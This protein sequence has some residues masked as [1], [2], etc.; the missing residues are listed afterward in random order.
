MF[1]GTILTLT[2][3]AATSGWISGNE[4]LMAVIPGLDPMMVN[5]A[6]C[7]F[8]AGIAL[9]TSAMTEGRARLYVVRPLA[10]ALIICGAL[11]LAEYFLHKD[12]GINDLIIKDTFNRTSFFGGHMTLSAALN[13]FLSGTALLFIHSPR[14]ILFRI[15]QTTGLLTGLISGIILV[16]YLYNIGQGFRIGPFSTMTLTSAALFFVLAVGIFG[17]YPDRGLFSVLYG[18]GNGTRIARFFLA[19]SVG[20]PV[21]VGF[22]V[23]AGENAGLFITASGSAIASIIDVIVPVIL[24]ILSGMWLNRS[25]QLVK[26]SHHALLKSEEHYRGLFDHMVEGCANH[27]MLFRDGVP[28]DYI[29]LD[30]NEAFKNMTGLTNVIGKRASEVVHNI[31]QDN[32]DI[33]ERYREVAGSARPSRFE[34]F[35]PALK[36]W[37]SIYFYCLQNDE[38]VTVIDNI[39]KRKEA[40][41]VIRLNEEKLRTLFEVLPVGVSFHDADSRIVEMNNALVKILSASEEA[42]LDGSHRVRTFLDNS[43]MPVSPDEWPVITAIREKMS[44]SDKEIGIRLE[45][46]ETRWVN[47]N[48]APVSI[49]NLGAVVVISDITRQKQGEMDL[50]ASQRDLRVTLTRLTE[51]EEDIRRKAAIELHDQVGQNLTALVI[52]MN[53]LKTQLI[54]GANPKLMKFLDDSILLLEDTIARTRDIMTE[55]RPAVLEDYG[56]YAAIQWYATQFSGRTGLTVMVKGH[57]LS[58]P[59]PS[60]VEYA[61]FRIVQEAFTNIAKHAHARK[62]CI[63]LVE[64]ENGVI[65]EIKDDG[66]GF[67]TGLL[68]H[69]EKPT[70]GMIVM[71]ERSKAAGGIFNITSLPGHG[72]TIT[73]KITS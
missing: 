48:A 49:A 12:I 11:T 51:M 31:Q 17:C 22:L 66:V 39:T 64:S 14:K 18:G 60:R 6:A 15:A 16:G 32:T 25:E 52:N 62:A 13:F 5:T 29:Y 73:F 54:S 2:G 24:I 71:K 57:D 41:E 55:L 33:F 47:V 46:G 30:V 72:T 65:L 63:S 38:F 1:T 21:I 8:L 7:F 56:L 9:L 70:L 35:S 34:T 20:V 50:V 58:R 37:F 69:K 43:G 36:S 40:D 27:K 28:Y 44:V 23:I 68:T 45:N 67:D 42:L 4:K 19:V 61:M 26:E 53:Y 10:L 3:L 59:L